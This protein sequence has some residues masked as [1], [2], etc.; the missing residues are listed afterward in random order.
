MGIGAALRYMAVMRAKL[1]TIVLLAIA[2]TVLAAPLLD[3]EDSLQE[4]TEPASDNLMLAQ[5]PPEAYNEP[6]AAWLRALS[7]LQAKLDLK[8]QGFPSFQESTQEVSFVETSLKSDEALPAMPPPEAD[9][10]SIR[11]E[12]PPISEVDAVIR[13]QQS[14]ELTQGLG[15]GLKKVIAQGIAAEAI[16]HAKSEGKEE[17]EAAVAKDKEQQSAAA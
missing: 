6:G 15:N 8:A 3:G 11:G 1:M 17:D 10:V 12:M 7:N 14:H 9:D 13:A 16:A 5:F 2:S 4:A